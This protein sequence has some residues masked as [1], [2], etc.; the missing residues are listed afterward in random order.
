MTPA[1][2]WWPSQSPPAPVRPL[3]VDGLPSSPACG[4][5][6]DGVV[7]PLGPSPSV[8]PSSG[9]RPGARP[10]SRGRPRGLTRTVTP[11][12]VPRQRPRFPCR[13][14]PGARLR[15]PRLLEAAQASP[16]APLGGTRRVFSGRIAFRM[17]CAAA[18]PRSD[19]FPNCLTGPAGWRSAGLP[20]LGRQRATTTQ[21]L[22][23]HDDLAAS[24][25]LSA[26]SRRMI[27]A[28]SGRPV[29]PRVA[30][31]PCELPGA[32]TGPSPGYWGLHQ[33]HEPADGTASKTHLDCS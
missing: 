26:R 30:S 11:S 4:S 29:G 21:L 23:R 9:G 13:A 7:E 20:L 10:H 31:W 14:R 33:V 27:A 28:P 22:T 32:A 15:G 8:T 18:A 1:A 2:S 19:G 25:R 12:A 16:A 6:W 17:P 24:R 3:G 5:G